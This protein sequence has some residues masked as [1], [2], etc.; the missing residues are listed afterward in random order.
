MASVAPALSTEPEYFKVTARPESEAPPRD[1]V[2]AQ[3]HLPQLAKT[4]SRCRYKRVALQFPDRL[5]PHSTV[6]ARVLAE[7]LE[8]V[9]DGAEQVAEVFVLGDTSYS[10][11]CVD[12]IAAQ[13]VNA[14]VVVH[15]GVACLSP[16][17]STPVIYLFGEEDLDIETVASSFRAEIED[18]SAHV[19]IVAETPYQAHVDR[20]HSL[21]SAEYPN[22]L[23]TIPAFSESAPRSLDLEDSSSAAATP[24]EIIIPPLLTAAGKT[25]HT[26]RSDV[27]NRS[28]PPL[29]APLQ[30]YTLF[31]IGTLPPAAH[32][33]LSTLLSQKPIII[34]PATAKPITSP[35]MPLARRYQT[36]M[37]ARAASTIGILVNTLSLRN[38]AAL[39]D[40]LKESIR[41]AGKKHYVIAVGKPNVAKLANFDVVDV[42]VI[43]GCARGGVILDRH[44]E[45]YKPIVTPYE[46]K[47]A[48][49][50]EVEWGGGEWVLE[51][52]KILALGDDAE[53]ED[54]DGEDG[55]EGDDDEDAPPE[56]D[57]VTGRYVSSRPL[58]ANT[59][60]KRTAKHVQVELESNDSKT[61]GS[62]ADKPSSSLISTK[63]NAGQLATRG[64]QHYS[65]AAAYLQNRSF[66]KGLGSDFQDEDEDEDEGGEKRAGAKLEDGRSG[67]ARG[68]VNPTDN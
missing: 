16:V 55:D 49:K 41:S 25:T 52:E 58:L 43:V 42:W 2:T 68:Y 40:A 18:K 32:L 6:V 27:P 31:H 14:D 8:A 48:L 37:T 15:V 12:E 38:S 24:S 46:L 28:H 17:V 26:V 59:R 10:E 51:F 66:W 30:D 5:L 44:G 45:Y 19:L 9:A 7:E 64:S 3:Y 20:L 21:L 29:A 67:I 53:D 33:H 34:D 56:F 62:S 39:I 65:T 61:I 57:P 50:R 1:K 36:M 63:G 60:Q 11:C 47:L 4:I 23:T 22:I 35:L 13:H 54:E